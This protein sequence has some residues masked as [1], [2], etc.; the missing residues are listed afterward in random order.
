[1]A[2]TITKLRR[3]MIA[4]F[5]GDDRTVRFFEQVQTY[6]ID[7]LPLSLAEI[8]RSIRQAQ[9]T[10]DDADAT[11]RQA[12]Y[13]PDKQD[14]LV[15]VPVNFARMD[16]QLND[17]PLPISIPSFL[18]DVHVRQQFPDFLPDVPV[19]QRM[20]DFL[21]DVIAPQDQRAFD[22]VTS[23][24]GARFT[25][26]SSGLTVNTTEV[27]LTAALG[28]GTLDLINKTPFYY[29]SGAN[30]LY[31]DLTV[32]EAFFFDI[33]L[34]LSGT[35]P[36]PASQSQPITFYLRR[37]DG[38]LITTADY[39]LGRGLSATFSNQTVVIPTFIFS[40]GA[41]PYQTLGFRISAAAANSGWSL[42]DK[43]LFLKR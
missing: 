33:V 1:M 31:V 36:S 24:F 13:K 19:P 15:D 22:A 4:K 32:V 9:S 11:A 39:V 29:D 5:A 6:L 2:D 40:G 12:L 43:L 34:R 18:P 41:D 28:G 17:V 30:L 27:D 26:T 10:A 23:S 20:P 3:D 7:A 21:L 37:G 8:I 38:S 35:A 25:G 42:T 14:L 16:A